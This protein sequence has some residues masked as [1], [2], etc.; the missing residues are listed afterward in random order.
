MVEQNSAAER[1]AEM[2]REYLD[3]QRHTRNRARETMFVYTD[4]LSKLLT[5]IGGTPLAAVSTRSLEEF[6]ER[7]RV[8]RRPEHVRGERIIGSPATRKRDVTVVRTFYKYLVE[9]GHIGTNPALL[10]S[11]PTVHNVNP[12]AIDD[13]LWRTLWLSQSLDDGDRVALGLGY[14]CGLRRAEVVDLKPVHVDA[15]A[16]RIVGFTRKGGLDGVFAYGSAATLIEQRLPHLI[17]GGAL[18]FTEPLRKL[19]TVREAEPHLLPWGDS[20]GRGD[21]HHL[22]GRTRLDPYPRGWAPPHTFNKRLRRCLTTCGL[23]AD[24]FTPHALRHSFVTNL[25]RAGVPL[26]VVSRQAAHSDVTTTL[27]YVTTSTDP[28]AELLDAPLPRPS[29]WQ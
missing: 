21:D 11:S 10:L 16:E 6:I 13:D 25:L 1:N 20:L 26:H 3:W 23:P 22:H 12:R 5:W 14:F 15:S 18:S 4:V 9:R 8:R 17:P 7:P 28:L 2:A 27:R 19:A 24:A 29:R